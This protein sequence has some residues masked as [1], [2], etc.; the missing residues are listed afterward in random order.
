MATLAVPSTTRV[1]DVRSFVGQLDR[2]L[3]TLDRAILIAEWDLNCGRS[4]IGSAPWQ[5]RRSRL[6]GDERILTWVRRALERNVPRLLHR[7]LELLERILLDAQVE[8]SEEVVRLRTGLQRKV[9]AFRPRWEGRRVNRIVLRH[10][11]RTDPDPRR[12]EAAYRGLEELHRPLE[13]GLRRLI[14]ARNE[15]ARVQGYRSYAAMRLGFEGFTVGRVEE[16]AADATEGA[17]RFARELAGSLG[18]GQPQDGWHPWDLQYAQERSL[19]L[20]DDAF[21]QRPMMGRVLETV[22]KWGFPTGRMRFRVVFH[23]LPSGGLTLAP[24][25]PRDVRILVHPQG[26]WEAYMVM[27]HEVGHAVHSASIRAPRHLLR[28]HENIPG[29][30]GFHEGIG[31]LFASVAHRTAWLSTFPAIERSLAESFEARSRSAEVL[32]VAS[33]VAWLSVEQALYR[34][35]EGD[36]MEVARRLERKLFGYADYDPLSFV[37]SFFIELPLYAPNYLF[38]ALVQHQL[39]RALVERFG[40][41]FWPN[42]KIGPWLSRE[43]FAPG[44]V[45]DW[46]PRLRELTG[47]PFGARDFRA[48]EV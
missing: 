1:A 14:I 16:L 7:R 18:P 37:D 43:C 35:P 6:L 17:P 15:G 5:I 25:P 44:S 3:E 27:L 32:A 22:R 40:T 21:P 36:P 9:V 2:R 10:V 38:A 31:E 29:F 46:V 19:R 13:A 34:R 47:R 28:W 20:P 41:P 30:G 48:G 45:F 12:R 39:A 26:G 4:R 8:Q 23:D 24:D 33:C 11:L 42:P